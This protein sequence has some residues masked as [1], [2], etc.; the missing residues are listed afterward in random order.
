MLDGTVRENR[1]SHSADR[2]VTGESLNL[3]ENGHRHFTVEEYSRSHVQI[4][5]DID[6]LKLH[7]RCARRADKS[8]LKTSGRHRYA[9]S[10][11]NR[12]ELSISRAN[13]G[14]LNKFRLGIAGKEL[15][16][17]VR[18]AQREIRRVHCTH[19]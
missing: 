15:R 4:D 5:A 10:N 8:R 19:V 12:G 7:N 3:H 11:A 9:R 17:R 1:L 2:S 13:A 16:D 6:V 14:V 18:Y